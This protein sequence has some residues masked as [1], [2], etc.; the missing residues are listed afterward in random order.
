LESNFHPSHPFSFGKGPFLAFV[1]SSFT[2][3][4]N[5]LV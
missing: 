5:F 3:S 2:R 4:L 1:S